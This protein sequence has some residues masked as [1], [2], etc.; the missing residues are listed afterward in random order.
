MGTPQAVIKQ[1][2][3]ILHSLQSEPNP[4]RSAA[5]LLNEIDNIHY[6]EAL[7][8]T[9]L[10]V[11]Y[12]LQH[13]T[14]SIIEDAL[15]EVGFHLDNALLTKLKR[16]LYYYSEETERANLGCPPCQD[17]TTREIFIKHYRSREHGCRDLRPLH[18]RQYL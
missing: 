7:T 2:D 3:I 17:K 13:I 15:R 18:W 16:S 10:L 5:L 9:R 8:E 12:N 6:V 14:L 11:R 1:R 4:A